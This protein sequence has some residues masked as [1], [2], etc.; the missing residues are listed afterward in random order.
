MKGVDFFPVTAT[1]AKRL[2]GGTFHS[3]LAASHRSN[4]QKGKKGWKKRR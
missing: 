2:V 3:V 1:N 4:L